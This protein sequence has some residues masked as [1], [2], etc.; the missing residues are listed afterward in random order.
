MTDFEIFRRKL[1]DAVTV[2]I[3]SGARVTVRRLNPHGFLAAESCPLG[4]LPSAIAE[5]RFR[6]FGHIDPSVG[7]GYEDSVAFAHGFDDRP[8]TLGDG[9]FYNLGRLYRERF[10]EKK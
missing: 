5:R 1:A 10:S 2:A 3:N 4:C 6:P 8:N 9:R 7:L